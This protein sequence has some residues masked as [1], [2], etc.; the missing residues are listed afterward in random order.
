MPVLTGCQSASKMPCTRAPAPRLAWRPPARQPCLTPLWS[1]QLARAAQLVDLAGE[2]V[3]SLTDPVDLVQRPSGQP[4]RI[5]QAERQHHEHDVLAMPKGLVLMNRSHVMSPPGVRPS[6]A[7]PVC[8][9]ARAAGRSSGSCSRSPEARNVRSSPSPARK[10]RP[11]G[12]KPDSI[13]ARSG[14]LTAGELGDSAG[15]RHVRR[16]SS[17]SRPGR[18]AL[19]GVPAPAPGRPATS[20]GAARSPRRRRRGPSRSSPRPAARSRAEV[21]QDARERAGSTTVGD[22]VGRGPKSPWCGR[23][24]QAGPMRC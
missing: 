6:P 23:T 7:G 10:S 18:R 15:E 9:C 3:L 19:R 17:P 8:V 20:R 5:S 14:S 11:Q 22:L 24:G 21:A 16:A 4:D 13:K 12:N 2:F 1:V